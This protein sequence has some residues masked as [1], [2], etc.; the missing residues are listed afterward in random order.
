MLRIRCRRRDVGKKN[1]EKKMSE[2]GCRRKNV[3]NKMLEKKCWKSDVGKMMDRDRDR[4]RLEIVIRIWIDR[5][6]EGRCWKEGMGVGIRKKE[7][8]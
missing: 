5:G 6:K 4:D 2:K 7:R 3:E 8:E 1:V